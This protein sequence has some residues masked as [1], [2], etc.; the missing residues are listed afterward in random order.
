M[1]ITGNNLD[2]HPV[3]I[4]LDTSGNNDPKIN[5]TINAGSS[6]STSLAVTLAIAADAL[7]GDR[8]VRIHTDGGR[9]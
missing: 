9:L 2:N 6:T 3:V 8:S 4:V 5:S 7:L 1:T